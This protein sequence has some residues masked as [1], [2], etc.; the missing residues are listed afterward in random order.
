MVITG[1]SRGVGAAVARLA[2]ER[3]FD[4]CIN[5]VSDLKAAEEV[6]DVVA[7]HG[8]RACVVQADV[9]V[10][11]EVE[12][13][14]A[15]IDSEF[16][17]LDVLVNNAGIAKPQMSLVQMDS[18]RLRRVFDVNVIGSFLCAREAVKRMSTEL[19]GAG[20]VII[21]MSSAAAR[22]G[23]PH[24]FI[25]YAASKG[26]MDTFTVGLSK[27]VADAGIRVNGIR[28]GLIDTE[29]HASYG[30]PNRA[31]RLRS[32]IPMQREGSAI[33]VAHAVLWLAGE[34]SSYVTGTTVDVSG[35]R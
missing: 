26:A 2:A 5:Y 19:G 27:E 24:E 13:L 18:D 8:R 7:S 17:R 22:L 23:S 21:N 3:E 16:G 1:G 11:A 25:D 32:S 10:E 35:G 9:S 4:V 33:E 29:I 15:A 31:V 6:A 12:S 28:P 34:E 14:F 20:G 30:E